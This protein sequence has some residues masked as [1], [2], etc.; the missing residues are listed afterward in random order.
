MKKTKPTPPQ[1]IHIVLLATLFLMGL[2]TAFVL[3]SYNYNPLVVTETRKDYAGYDAMGYGRG[4]KNGGH[5]VDSHNC[6]MDGCLLVEDAEFP[7][8]ELDDQTIE[9]L[10]MALADERKAL[11]TYEAIMEDFGR[12]RPFINISRAEE[13]HISMVKALYDKYGIDIPEEERLMVDVPET[14]QEA[15]AIGVEAEIKNDAM[16]QAMLNDI[17]QEDIKDI[18]TSL[19]AASKQMHLPA[20]ERCS[21]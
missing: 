18:F 16:Y 10:G 20:F 14:L 6:L 8:E 5:M 1:P 2:I 21:N 11:A 19:A 17:E 7:V 12:V 3:S 15:C 13:H 9:Y 4:Y